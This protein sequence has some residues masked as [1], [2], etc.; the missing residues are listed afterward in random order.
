MNW[1]SFLIFA[2]ILIS[3]TSVITAGAVYVKSKDKMPHLKEA[4][5]G[6][7]FADQVLQLV[8]KRPWTVLAIIYGYKLIGTA[9]TGPFFLIPLWIDLR[10][11]RYEALHLEVSTLPQPM[12]QAQPPA[13][14]NGRGQE[15]LAEHSVP[16][17]QS[18]QV[19]GKIETPARPVQ[20]QPQRPVSPLSTPPRTTHVGP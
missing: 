17:P 4:L 12:P 13:M 3:A 18:A 19:P 1:Y 8:L 2:Y 5:E 10:N 7:F 16:G 6:T 11:R 14:S 15:S 9:L 20:Q